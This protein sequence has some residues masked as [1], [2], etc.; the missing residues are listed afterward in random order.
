[1]QHTKCCTDVGSLELPF[2]SVLKAT[3]CLKGQVS[4]I[5]VLH[6]VQLYLRCLSGLNIPP[7]SDIKRLICPK[8]V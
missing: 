6:V 5:I 7:L 1:M 2:F 8:Y 4:N 3:V